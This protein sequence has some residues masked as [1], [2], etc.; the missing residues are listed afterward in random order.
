ME[1][2][3]SILTDIIHMKEFV[4]VSQHI[5]VYGQILLVIK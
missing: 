1:I 3:E 4:A 5:N 2:R